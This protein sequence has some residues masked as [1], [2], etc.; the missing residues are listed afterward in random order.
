MDII[1]LLL[2]AVGLAMDAFSVSVTDGIILKNLKVKQAA[3]ISLYFGAFQFGMLY[4]GY[5]LGG[6]FA[7]YISA[8]DHWIAFVLLMLIGGKMFYE[9]VFSKE[10]EKEDI[11]NPLSNKTLTVLAIATS[12]DA[13]AVGVSFAA[14]SVDIVFAAS[15]VGIVAFVFSFGGTY[16]GN[17]CGNLFGNKS[18]IIGGV[19][20]MGIGV[21]ILIEHLFF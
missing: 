1:T 9:A 4:L 2:I 20:L 21:K 18:E 8:F 3:K 6:T 13:L 15:V 16:I 10:E 17:K 11:K 7:S 5:L 19:V 12:I 14:M